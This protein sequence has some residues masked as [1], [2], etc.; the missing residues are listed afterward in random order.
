MQIALD[1]GQSEAFVSVRNRLRR[2]HGCVAYEF[3][4]DPVA[5]LIKSMLSTHTHDRVSSAALEQLQRRYRSWDVLAA[6]PVAE[7]ETSIAAVTYPTG[8]PGYPARAGGSDFRRSLPGF[9]ARMERR[10]IAALSGR[11]QGRRAQD[12]RRLL[13]F[14]TLRKPALVI[15]SHLLRVLGRLGFIGS[16]V[17]DALPAYETVMPS[18]ADWTAGEMFEL[19]LLIKQLGREVCRPDRPGLPC[20][21][22]G[23]AVPQTGPALRRWLRP[24]MG[25]YT[26]GGEYTIVLHVRYPRRVLAAHRHLL[27][28]AILAAPLWCVA[29]PAMPD[30]PAHLA[31]FYLIGGGPSAYYTVAWDFLPNLASEALVPLAAKLLPLGTAA[32]VFL[33]LTVFFWVLGP[34]AIQYALFGR[35]SFGALFAALFAYNANFQWGFFNY[36]FATGLSFLAFAA[37][38]ATDRRRT[39]THSLG[40]ALAFTAIYFAHLFALAVLL[41]AIAGFEISGWRQNQ[42]RRVA[43][44]FRR[45]GNVAL[46]CLPAAARLPV[47]QTAGHQQREPGIRSPGHVR[48][49]LRGRDPVRFRQAGDDPDRAADRGIGR[50]IGDA[51][52]GGPSAPGDPAG[53][54]R[55]HHPHRAAMG[56]GRLGGSSAPAAVLGALTFASVEWRLSPRLSM[57]FAGVALALL[58][59]GAAALGTGW[60]T[61]DGQ[62]AEF[63]AHASDVRKARG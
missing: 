9:P 57:A 52:R 48:R 49:P 33:T 61:Y 16:R 55:G 39:P 58:T 62:F 15:D 37:W 32:R 13:N 31:S 11:V 36:T 43:S 38:I 21:S 56:A 40:F 63:R 50:G 22:A 3:L 27:A 54:A 7:I 60:Q 47:P 34:A 17:S 18:L 5:Q 41:L 24:A 44:L 8:R 46:L 59:A 10:G 42:E 35:V 6:A 30:Y 14:S 28:A 12:L 45:A 1:F 23:D 2:L 20:L 19:H 4:R 51:A 26:L 53:R 25:R 29:M